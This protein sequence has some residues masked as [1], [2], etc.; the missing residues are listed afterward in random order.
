[1]SVLAEATAAGFRAKE[2]ASGPQSAAWRP[3][4][5]SS[6]R[7][8]RVRS[9]LRQLAATSGSRPSSAAPATVV[10]RARSARSASISTEMAPASAMRFS[11][12]SS[13]ASPPGGWRPSARAKAAA[14]S[15][16]SFPSAFRRS[17]SRAC[18]AASS[19]ARARS[20]WTSCPGL[21]VPASPAATTSTAVGPRSVRSAASE[22]A[23]AASAFPASAPPAGLDFGSP[24]SSSQNAFS[25]TK[26]RLRASAESNCW[27]HPSSPTGTAGSGRSWPPGTTAD[28]GRRASWAVGSAAMA[29]SPKILTK[30]SMS[31]PH[32][33]SSGGG[34][35]STSTSLPPE[36]DEETEA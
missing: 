2:G 34:D 18:S 3:E 23:V 5:R 35:H 7:R 24:A 32:S 30:Y 22:S 12:L 27:V 9:A 33:T 20:C 25:S 28:A 8:R 31:R 13:A 36:T 26:L 29:A 21:S 19:S 1:M 15:A 11:C 17:R 6:K 16:C 14:T 4:S 10:V